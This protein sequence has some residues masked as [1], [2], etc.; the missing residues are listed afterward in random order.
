[1]K[2]R[3][4]SLL[5]RAGLVA[6]LATVGS[7]YAGGTS[8]SIVFHIGTPPIYAHPGPV[9]YRH[10]PPPRHVRRAPPPRQVWVPGH[11]E[12]V[13]PRGDFRRPPGAR[14]HGPSR[15]DHHRGARDGRYDHRRPPPHRPYN[16][17]YSRR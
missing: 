5:S 16:D 6:L 13:R 3:L 10:A 15:V 17:H 14:T 12:T 7:A 9:H 1:M 11:W 4:F 2:H 8:A